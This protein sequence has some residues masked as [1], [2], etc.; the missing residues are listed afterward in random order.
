MLKIK[1]VPEQLFDIVLF[2]IMMLLMFTYLFGGAIAGGTGDYLQ[3]LL[4]GIMVM[5]IVMT[6][7]YTGMGVNIDIQKECPTGSRRC[8]SGGP[9]RWSDTCWRTRSGTPPPGR[10]CSAPAW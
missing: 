8:R 10:S 6:T 9:P 5:S 7:M 2:P 4:P 1:H 3:F